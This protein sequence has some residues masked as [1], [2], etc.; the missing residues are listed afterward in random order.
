MAA[1]AP[2][3]ASRSGRAHHESTAPQPSPLLP[4]QPAQPACL[5]C[6]ADDPARPG[7][8]PRAL[9]GAPRREAKQ[10]FGD[11]QWR[12]E[13]GA[14]A[15]LGARAGWQAACV[16]TSL[17]H[18]LARP[19]T[20]WCLVISG[21]YSLCN[22]I[23]CLQADFGLARTFGSPDRRYTNQ[24]C[25]A[26]GEAGAFYCCCMALQG[27]HAAAQGAPLQPR[28]LPGRTCAQ[29]LRCCTRLLT[30]QVF[31]R[32]Y[33]PPELFY[34]STCYGP[35]VDIWAAGE[36][37]PAPPGL[38]WARPCTLLRRAA[39]AQRAAQP[40]MPPPHKAAPSLLAPPQAAFSRSCCA[41]APG[42]LESRVRAG[43][44]G[45]GRWATV[46]GW[47][48]RAG[49]S[50]LRLR[51][52]PAFSQPSPAFFACSAHHWLAHQPAPQP[53]SHQ[54]TNPPKQT[55]RCWARSTTPWAR[56]RTRAG[57][58]CA[59]CPALWS[60]RC[61]QAWVCMCVRSN[62]CVRVGGVM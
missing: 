55:W 12:A 15:C 35:G 33:R 27:M 30:V 26:P 34:G 25:P 36:P 18:R 51:R 56:R 3:R 53:T 48:G 37:A 11:S 31:A 5:A 40:A 50:A 28:A 57:R 7:V 46:L 39:C 45:W 60:S 38:P 20:T 32:W 54:P 41:A 22:R 58:G 13:A 2:V 42:S 8:L 61:G 21:F 49:G 47:P 17:R 4:P 59:P 24:V 14:Q 16:R 10:L 9:G 62:K 6:S 43:A 23:A 29:L 1:R 19:C 52:A 44:G